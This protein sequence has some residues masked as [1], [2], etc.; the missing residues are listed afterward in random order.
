M[1]ELLPTLDAL[2]RA[3]P[4]WLLAMTLWTLGLWLC[5][6]TL[7]ALLRRRLAAAWRL[8][9]YGVVLARLVLPVDWQSPIVAWPMTE[10]DV[11][12]ATVVV[13][14]AL[15]PPPAPTLIGASARLEAPAPAPAPEVPWGLAVLL[16]WACGAALLLARQALHRRRLRAVAGSGQPASAVARR[17]VPAR[18]RVIVHPQRGPLAFGVRSPTIV[19]PRA[20]LSAGP[21]ALRCVLAHELAHLE[22]RDPVTVGALA[23]VVALAWPVLPVWLAA[24]RIRALLELAADER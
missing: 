4:T 15:V 6:R 17:S 12:V 5:A 24:R 22:R 10:D 7:D 19:L 21:A 9:L 23:V 20:L 3:A 13:D 2:G 18:V 11:A 16:T 8:P 1:P 14:S